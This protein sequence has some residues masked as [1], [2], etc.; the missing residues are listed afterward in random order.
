MVQTAI[1]E[2]IY[3]S[4]DYTFR[5]DILKINDASFSSTLVEIIVFV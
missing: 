5:L 4:R 3:I 2:P 1:A